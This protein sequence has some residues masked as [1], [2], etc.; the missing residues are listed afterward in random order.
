MDKSPVRAHPIPGRRQAS[1]LGAPGSASSTGSSHLRNPRLGFLVSSII[2]HFHPLS[3]LL[4][5]NKQEID[6]AL[7]EAKCGFNTDLYPIIPM[8]QQ[9]AKTVPLSP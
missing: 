8:N 2:P 5:H 1:P 7:I 9:M 6:K 4:S 3:D